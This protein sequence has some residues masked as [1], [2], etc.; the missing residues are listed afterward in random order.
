L[1]F[2]GKH[3]IPKDPV[4]E[5]H[6]I[7]L[8][9][10]NT[11]CAKFGKRYPSLFRLG[12]LLSQI[13]EPPLYDR[14]VEIIR[15][16]QGRKTYQEALMDEIRKEIYSADLPNDLFEQIQ[17]RVQDIR[18]ILH[19]QVDEEKMIRIDDLHEEI[20]DLVESRIGLNPDLS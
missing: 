14:V 18:T 13:A 5:W 7:A 4:E 6:R 10:L 2:Y 15:E 1:D 9:R 11:Y 16:D 17:Q 20:L 8:A 12:Y 3:P 19:S